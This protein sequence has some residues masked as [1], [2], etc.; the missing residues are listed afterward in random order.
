MSDH[1]EENTPNVTLEDIKKF[2][3]SLRIQF[4]KFF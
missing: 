3:K 4:E 1:T 2:L